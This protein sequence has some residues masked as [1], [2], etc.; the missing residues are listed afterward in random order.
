[1]QDNHY[2]LSDLGW[3]PFFSS[4]LSLSDLNQ[5]IPVRVS[6]VH[7]SHIQV[8]GASLER[9]IPPYLADKNDE[10]QVATVG[11]WLL[12]D[13]QTYR[14]IRLLA[15][16]S[17]F[18]RKAPGTGRKLQLIAA[19]VDTLFIV[20]SCNQDFNLARLERYLALA[21]EAQVTPVILLTKADLCD[22]PEHYAAL[23][24]DAIPGLI[25]ETL[26]ALDP[27]S[28]AGLLTWCAAGQTVALVGS[29]GVGKSTLV[30][31]LAMCNTQT[32][33]IRSGD[34]KGRHT[35]TS[36]RLYPLPSG[37]WLVDTPGMRELQLTD[38]KQGLEEVFHDLAS[39]ASQCRFSDCSHHTE[40]GCTVQPAIASGE[41]DAKRLQH[42]QKLLAEERY[43]TSSLAERRQ[44]DREF[45]KIVKRAY[46]DKTLKNQ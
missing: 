10:E 42:W 22:Q 6:A 46:Q 12:L 14:P 33:G 21:R 44:R 17:L 38:V 20:S 27:L 7:R 11:D 36:R 28:T 16:S 3:T 41:L 13:A 5:C 15:R 18:K 9:Q 43:N 31:T 26:N 35:T 30:N 24:T 32:Q 25:V 39:L 37:G 40:P 29:S 34:D 2:E 19:N 45:G 23:I 4:Q 8:F 1:M